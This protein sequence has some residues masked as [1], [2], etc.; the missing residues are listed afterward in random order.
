MRGKIQKEEMIK[1]PDGSSV[2]AEKAKESLGDIQIGDSK[3]QL[4]KNQKNDETLVG[5]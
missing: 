5:I 3:E 1:E 4:C 2:E